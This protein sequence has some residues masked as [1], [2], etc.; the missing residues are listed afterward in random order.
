L[1]NSNDKAIT[2]KEIIVSTLLLGITLLLY[3]KA[4]NNG[5]IVIQQCLDD[6][7]LYN[8]FIVKYSS[9]FSN[10]FGSAILPMKY[11]NLIAAYF[12][13]FIPPTAFISFWLLFVFSYLNQ[14]L[15]KNRLV[16]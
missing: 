1:N 13:Y 12:F 16:N 2:G 14:K 4:A 9:F 15:N 8:D 7:P 10:H 11:E 5:V 3:F 6:S